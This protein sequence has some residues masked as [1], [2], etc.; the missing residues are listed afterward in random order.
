[1]TIGKKDP[2]PQVNFK[3][4]HGTHMSIIIF[5]SNILNNLLNDLFIPDSLIVTF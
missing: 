3:D 1:M 5:K 2:L 4:N